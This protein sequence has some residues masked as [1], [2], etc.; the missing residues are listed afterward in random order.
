LQ[1]AWHANRCQVRPLGT[2]P[3][4]SAE[5]PL[6]KS[7]FRAI[8]ARIAALCNERSPYS[9]SPYGGEGELSLGTDPLVVF[10]VAF[11]NTPGEQ[12]LEVRRKADEKDG[13]KEFTVLLRV[14][15]TGND[16]HVVKVRGY[17]LQRVA[18]KGGGEPSWLGVLAAPGEEDVYAALFPG[19]QVIAAFCG[20]VR[21]AEPGAPPDRGDVP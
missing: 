8:V 2:G 14:S 9:V 6:P 7:V 21:L 18:P 12:R 10:R 5:V 16:V 20:E 11:A 4:E 19:G 3:Q 13:G 17:R 15:A 1:L